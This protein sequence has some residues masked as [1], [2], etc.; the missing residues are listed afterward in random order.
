L[1]HIGSRGVAVR[2]KE[3]HKQNN[4]GNLL[5]E[6]CAGRGGLGGCMGILSYSVYL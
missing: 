5:P 6:E 4:F 1:R 2:Y 3:A